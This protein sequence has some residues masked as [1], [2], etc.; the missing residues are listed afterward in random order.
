[1]EHG[2][3][4]FDV[5]IKNLSY[6]L[7]KFNKETKE[8][9]KIEKWGIINLQNFDW[10]PENHEKKCSGVLKKQDKVCNKQSV[11]W[12]FKDDKR[13]E[14]CHKHKEDKTYFY[15]LN[16]SKCSCSEKARKVIFEG[17]KL[18]NKTYEVF[19][20]K[21]SKKQEGQLFKIKEIMKLDDNIYHT[22]LYHALKNLGLNEIDEVVIENQ[23]A[24][25]NPKMKSIQMLVYSFYFMKSIEEDII[26]S[27]IHFFN[28]SKKLDLSDL[29]KNLLQIEVDI[30]TDEYKKRKNN[31]VLIVKNILQ[32]DWLPFFLKNNKK[33]DLAD[34]FLQGLAQWNKT[35][36]QGK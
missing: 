29:V 12:I 17:D 14:V 1:M 30:E 10:I 3:L 5:G 13:M 26:K 36:Q 11:G 8:F 24:F 35:I 7:L 28:A 15:D 16:L 22:K 21:C 32:E 27:G 4:S 23:P 34:S 6:C 18:E 20:N 25:K 9:L 33:D 2:I 31:A 19:C